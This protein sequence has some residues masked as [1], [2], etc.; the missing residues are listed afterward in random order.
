MLNSL[1]FLVGGTIHI[2]AT[3]FMILNT[4]TTNL[5]QSLK[6]IDLWYYQ[7]FVVPHPQ[8]LQHHVYQPPIQNRYE[9]SYFDIPLII[10]HE[11]TD[12]FFSKVKPLQET[13]P[14]GGNNQF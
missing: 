8:Q 5:Y 11:P 2:I 12:D 7:R 6:K 3:V 10:G 14:V 13:N 9:T 4:I 1:N